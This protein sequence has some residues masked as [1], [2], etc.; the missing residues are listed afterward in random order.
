MPPLPFFKD[1]MNGD[2]HIKGY[3]VCLCKN[4]TPPSGRSKYRAWLKSF[5]SGLMRKQN[6]KIIKEQLLDTPV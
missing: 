6:R 5:R 1:T 3:A 2:R 4:C